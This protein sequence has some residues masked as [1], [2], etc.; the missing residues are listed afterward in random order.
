MQPKNICQSCTMPIDN[1]ED[2][3]TEKNGSK[4]DLYCKYCY[5]DG[6]L[7]DPGMTI[8][9][10]KK[11]V[12]T[13]MQKMHLPENLIQRS[14]TMLPTLKRWAGKVLAPSNTLVM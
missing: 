1:F 5:K 13:Q 3:G 12:T 7:I 10:M 2:R 6:A 14:V 11:I 8:D 4:S 9:E